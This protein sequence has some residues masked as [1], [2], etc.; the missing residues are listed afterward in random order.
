[1]F[2]YLVMMLAAWGH[3]ERQVFSVIEIEESNAASYIQG[4]I[5]DMGPGV[6]EASKAKRVKLMV[7]PELDGC[8]WSAKENALPPEGGVLLYKRGPEGSQC[9]FQNKVQEATDFGA[10]AVLIANYKDTVF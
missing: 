8:L 1:M 9:T 7:N 6:V 2:F 3:R 5:S 10:S 4:Y